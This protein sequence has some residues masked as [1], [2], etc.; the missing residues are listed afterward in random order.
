MFFNKN[1]L[2]ENKYLFTVSKSRIIISATKKIKKK[3]QNE[4]KINNKIKY[5][6][7]DK[8]IKQ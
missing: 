3:I 6:S 4:L 2:K 1:Y 7:Y 5:K 8:F